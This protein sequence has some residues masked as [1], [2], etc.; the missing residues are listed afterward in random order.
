[1][2][3]RC[4]AGSIKLSTLPEIVRYPALHARLLNQLGRQGWILGDFSYARLVLEESRAIW[5]KLGVDGEQ[6]LAETLLSLGMVARTNEGDNTTAQSLYEQS[7]ELCQKSNHQRGKASVMF[8]LGWIAADRDQ[9]ASAL[10]WCEQSLDLFRQLGDGWG[11]ARASQILGQLYL[12]QGNYEKAYQYFEQHLNIDEELH[13]SQGTVVALGNLG[14]LYRFQGD[15]AQA[16]LFYQKSLTVSREYDLK[17]DDG[18]IL[19]LQGILALQRNDYRL[20]C[21]L[22]TDY[23]DLARKM[24]DAKIIAGDLLIGLA[25]VAGGTDQPE[26]AAKLNGAAHAILDTLDKPYTAFD[27][28][29]F[30]RH[31]RLAREQLGDATFEAHRTEGSLMSLEDAIAFALED[32]FLRIAPHPDSSR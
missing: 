31:I 2:L 30:D 1:M 7:L 14:N 32:S 22:F 13:F 26:R 19:W 5:L 12:E 21:Q 27:Q 11:I 6:G 25:A 9:H 24:Y 17:W 10:A 18:F 4:A 28:A 8:N 3:T 16:E 29:E 23:Y 15:Y 20:A